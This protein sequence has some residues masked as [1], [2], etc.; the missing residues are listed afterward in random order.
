MLSLALLA[1][2]CGGSSEASPLKKPVFVKE[3][4]AICA[5]AQSE[6]EELRKELAE[7]DAGSEDTEGVMQRIL[8]PVED[9]TEEIAD[10]GAPV[11][12]EQEVEAIVSAYEAGIAKLEADPAGPQTVSAFAKANQL[13]EA[14]GLTGC[15]I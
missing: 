3:A 10:L 7:D 4:D 14:Y 9:M 1:T 13:A 5:A 6:R 11:G 8:E 12:Q 15:T 2:G